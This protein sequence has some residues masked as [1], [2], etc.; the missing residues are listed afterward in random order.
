MRRAPACCSSTSCADMSSAARSRDADTRPWSRM[1]PGCWR[2]RGARA[3]WWRSRRPITAPTARRARRRCATPTIACGR[4]IP[5][6]SRRRCPSS[7]AGP[8]RRRSSPRLRRSRTSMSCRN[9]DG[10]RSMARISSSR[11][12][13]EPD[14]DALRRAMVDEISTERDGLP[15]RFAPEVKAAMLRVPRHL[16][17]PPG[18]ERYAY[19]NVPLPI[20]HGQTI[21]QPYI[22]ALMTD[23]LRLEPQ[24]AVLEVG[25]GSGYQAAILAEVAQKVCTIEIIEPLAQNAA[26]RLQKLGYSRVRT[27]QGDGFY[28]WEDC[29][30]FDSII[31]T[32]AA[33]RIPPPLI[34]QLKP[35]GRMVIPVGAA[36][37]TQQLILV[38]KNRDGTG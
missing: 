14:Y 13:G 23:L 9:I 8:S 32:A 20:G 25:T 1:P 34:Q 35:G 10:A 38:E 17:V 11:C 26:A 18:V 6:T 4:S 37:L 5:P 22:V 36:F 31:V 15:A 21:S 24:H 16:F 27:K 12:A 28:G 2:P 3:R 29:G 7:P 19:D 30:P 33:G